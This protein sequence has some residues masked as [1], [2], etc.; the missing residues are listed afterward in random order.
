MLNLQLMLICALVLLL[1]NIGLAWWGTK[2]FQRETILTQ[3]K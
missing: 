2:I 1:V 3:W